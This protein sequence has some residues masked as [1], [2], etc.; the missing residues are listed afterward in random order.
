MSEMRSRRRKKDKN[1]SNLIYFRLGSLALA[2]LLWFYVGQ[3]QNVIKE[4]NYT[5][6]VELRNLA[7]EHYTTEEGHQV[8][9]TVKGSKRDIEA[10]KNTDIRAYVNLDGLGPGEH[11]L[12]VALSPL[13]E[14]VQLVAVSPTRLTVEIGQL[15]T[16]VFELSIIEV[17]SKPPAPG[18][19]RSAPTAVIKE[20]S[21]SGPAEY[22]DKI[23]RVFVAITPEART[24]TYTQLLPVQVVDEEGKVLTQHFT[25]SPAS[26]DVTVIV[27]S[28]QP[29]K[30][31]TINPSAI[32]TPAPGYVLTRIIVE[33]ETVKVYGAW[34]VL[35]NLLSVSTASIDIGGASQDIDVSVDITTPSGVSLGEV[36]R[37]RV[38]LRIE[39]IGE[40]TFENLKVTVRGWPA[41]PEAEVE[42][43]GALFANVTI[44]GAATLVA[45]IK[46]EDIQLYLDLN[47]LLPGE[48]IV[49]LRIALPSGKDISL[50]SV[51]PQRITVTITVPQPPEP[52]GGEDA[53]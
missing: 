22:L 7:A 19:Q 30:T 25:I 24:A 46:A 49:N 35:Q 40:K 5:V 50:V 9:V 17:D 52:H 15:E 29:D 37:V 8:L 14:G 2:V 32:G 6:P 33:P 26:V 43:G 38:I 18:Y 53:P 51:T 3:P 39:P 21:I 34:S 27:T 28:D 12:S 16:R 10:L 41:N 48:H 23:A 20:V 1:K 36:T 45:Q 13:P 44:S 47:G 31:V 4:S 42:L 11:E